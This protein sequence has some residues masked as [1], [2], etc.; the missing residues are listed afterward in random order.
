LEIE[1]KNDLNKTDSLL[2]IIY[3]FYQLI[4]GIAYFLLIYHFRF[5]QK[6]NISIYVWSIEGFL[7]NILLIGITLLPLFLILKIRNQTFESIGLSHKNIL[8]S[9]AS[10]LLCSLPFFALIILND[11]VL[12]QSL[13]TRYLYLLGYLVKHLIFVG[14]FEEIIFTGYFQSRF[15]ILFKNKWLGILLVGFIFAIGHMPYQIM[16]T[17]TQL[18]NYFSR[19]WFFLISTTFLHIIKTLLY[20]KR[21]NILAPAVF[22]GLIN[23]AYKIL[24]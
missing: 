19:Y 3:I 2:S 10:G 4:I 13:N 11:F 12:G 5:F 20:I 17:D 1:N 8:S 15:I 9:I 18:S 6:N 16:R 14:L 23:L 21:K 7:I 22:H 24:V